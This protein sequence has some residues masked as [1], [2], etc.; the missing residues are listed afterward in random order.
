MRTWGPSGKNPSRCWVRRRRGQ[1]GDH[2]G[3]DE[4]PAQEARDEGS[5][6]PTPAGRSAWCR[7]LEMA[8]SGQGH[9]AEGRCP[10]PRGGG[11]NICVKQPQEGNDLSLEEGPPGCQGI[12]DGGEADVQGGGV[13]EQEIFMGIWRQGFPQ[14]TVTMMRRLPSRDG[15]AHKHKEK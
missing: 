5:A 10:A 9:A 13:A 7:G 14:L 8:R 3:V 4:A 15:H 2:D 12:S 11:K 6:A 1:Q